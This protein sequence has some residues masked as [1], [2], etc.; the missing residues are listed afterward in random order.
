MSPS[1]S[2]APVAASVVL[3]PAAPPSSEPTAPPSTEPDVPRDRAAAPAEVVLDVQEL[4]TYFFTYEG[5]VRALDGVTFRLRRGETTGLVGETGCGKSVTA[6]SIAR[7][8]PDPPGRIFGGHILLGGSDL[9]R[10][11][12]REAT[13][14]T[15]PGSDRVRVRRRFR[16]IRRANERMEAVRG[17]KIAMIFQEPTQALNPVFSIA[18]QVGELL[19]LHHGTRIIDEMLGAT[20]LAPGVPQAVDALVAAA[21]EGDHAT[22]RQA[23]TALADVVR[24]Q[25]LAAEAYYLALAPGRPAILRRL[26]EQALA[27]R[28]VGGLERRYLLH[29]RRLLALR[30]QRHQIY[31]AELAQRPVAGGVSARL[32]AK[33]L[34]EQLAHLYFGLWGLRGHVRRHLDRELLWRVVQILEGVR[35]ANPVQVAQGYP[36][37]LSGGMIQ[38]VMIA[39]ALL[40]EPDVLLAD[41]PTTALDVTIQAQILGL[42]D[43]LRRRVGT[44]IL[45]ITH[46]LAVVAEVADRVCVMYAGVIV[47][48]APVKEL[49]HQ[50]LHPYTQGLLA[51]VPRLDQPG[52]SLRTIAGSVP[53]LTHPPPGCRFHPRC[54]HAMPICR[55]KRPP[56]TQEGPDHTVACYLYHGPSGAS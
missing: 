49:F 45:L 1:A 38:R 23:A 37:E 27:H 18:N 22:I 52:K 30:D 20:P 21:G 46:D 53:D 40:G 13:F 31:L 48:Q 36:H 56:V 19:L 26:L 10:G 54:P 5:V 43:D 15:I 7:L 42:L 11:L 47:E 3:F 24:S 14:R 16:R 33:L 34:R 39:M 25:G 55:E 35:I 4:R 50:P 12:E 6:F 9:L 17:R 28:Q 51:S 2:A 44:A 29:R 32:R 41:E 8:I